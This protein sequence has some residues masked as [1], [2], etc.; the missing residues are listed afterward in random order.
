[1]LWVGPRMRLKSVVFWELIL[2]SVCGERHDHAGAETACSHRANPATSRMRGLTWGGGSLTSER[3]PRSGE[4][5]RRSRRIAASPAD[6][7]EEA[8]WARTVHGLLSAAQVA[9]YG[10]YAEP[11]SVT[12]LERFVH[13][14][15]RDRGLISRRRGD[16]NQLGFAAQLGTVRF[17]GTFLARPNLR[18][19]RGSD[20]RAHDPA[21]RAVALTAGWSR[22]VPACA[23]AKVDTGATAGTRPRCVRRVA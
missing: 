5:A 20:G 13:F 19:E 17:L 2:S 11:P 18:C 7:G 22:R 1:M 16:H 12:Q 3:P 23:G 6:A 15:E 8:Q 10:R 14:G 4:R 21:V 9:A